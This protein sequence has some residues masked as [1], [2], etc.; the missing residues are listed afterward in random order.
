MGENA[1][2]ERDCN[3]VVPSRPPKVLHHLPI[4]CPRKRDDP[5]HI[6]WVTPN[7]HYVT[8][9]NRYIRART[10]RDTDVCRHQGRGIVHAIAHH[11]NA[12]T[13]PLKFL[14]LIS[15]PFGKDLRK[16]A[17]NSELARHGISYDL[18]VAGEHGHFQTK[19]MEPPDCIG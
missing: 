8:G 6:S 5:R 4:T 14:D 10:Y 13:L 19:L 17:I 9:L 11:G 15:L 2:R 3:D 16:N 12:L 1:C 18:S 7:E